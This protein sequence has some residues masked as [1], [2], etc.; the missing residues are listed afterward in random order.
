MIVHSVIFLHIHHIFHHNSAQWLFTIVFIHN[1]STLRCSIHINHMLTLWQTNNRV[2][3]IIVDRSHTVY[4]QVSWHKCCAEI[5]LYVYT[6][7][8]PS[9]GR[10]F[11][12]VITFQLVIFTI[13]RIW[14][15]GVDTLVST[16]WETIPGLCDRTILVIIDHTVIHTITALV[17][18]STTHKRCCALSIAHSLIRQIVPCSQFIAEHTLAQICVEILDAHKEQVHFWVVYQRVRSIICLVIL[19]W[20]YSISSMIL[21]LWYHGNRHGSIICFAIIY[22]VKV[23]YTLRISLSQG[24]FRIIR[25]GRHQLRTRQQSTVMRY[26]L[27]FGRSSYISQVNGYFRRLTVSPVIIKRFI[28]RQGKIHTNLWPVAPVISYFQRQAFRNVKAIHIATRNWLPVITNHT[29]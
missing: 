28:P 11:E 1:R 12:F 29:L 16:E 10:E 7:R 2:I 6:H 13:E 8:A 18:I 9:G 20:W 25:C 15:E 27:P 17:Y 22:K 4:P 23:G 24:H 21:G 14:R 26:N 3:I 19:G 5:V